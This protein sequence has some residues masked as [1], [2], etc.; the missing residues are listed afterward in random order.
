MKFIKQITLILISLVVFF[1]NIHPSQTLSNIPGIGNI[2]LD[3]KIDLNNL[4]K[5]LQSE[6]INLEKAEYTLSGT[7]KTD[8]KFHNIISI[9]NAVAAYSPIKEEVF[10]IG[11]PVIFGIM[12]PG[13]VILSSKKEGGKWSELT[14]GGQITS[15]SLGDLLPKE[16]ENVKKELELVIGPL[17]TIEK[18]KIEINPTTK[19]ISIIG[20][21]KFFM[22]ETKTT[23]N[24]FDAEDKKGIEI[25]AEGGNLI[26]KKY[27]DNLQEFI[28]L[29]TGKIPFQLPPGIPSPADVFKTV[30]EFSKG[31]ATVA[32]HLALPLP[33]DEN[34][35]LEGIK[36]HIK[37]L[38]IKEDFDTKLDVKAEVEAKVNRG[39]LLPF[40]DKFL[41]V[42]QQD[43]T[44]KLTGLINLNQLIVMF[45]AD[46]DSAFK[47]EAGPVSVDP[48][49]R[50]ELHLTPAPRLSIQG[51]I[52]LKFPQ[53]YDPNKFDELKF[54][55]EA[56]P[57]IDTIVF[58]GSMEGMWKNA[59]GIPGFDIGNL[60]IESDSWYAAMTEG[61]FIT[62][63]GIT[64]EVKIGESDIRVAVALAV[65]VDALILL[66]EVNKISLHDIL[67]FS[68]KIMRIA[69]PNIS[70]TMDSFPKIEFTDCKLFLAP[71]PGGIG[72]LNF[73]PG[74]TLRGKLN[75]M[76]KEGMINIVANIAG[77]TAE[78]SLPTLEIPSPI[79]N[80]TLFKMTGAGLDKIKGTKDD[81]PT[82]SIQNN[83]LKQEF[84]LSGFLDVLGMTRET[85]IHLSKEGFQFFIEGKLF[86]F[87]DAKLNAIGEIPQV[88]GDF[89][90]FSLY[91]DLE[92]FGKKG[93][94]NISLSK[95][96]AIGNGSL[97]TIDIPS[98]IHNLP[99]FRMSGAGLDQKKGTKDDGPS[100]SVEL[101]PKK[102]E[103]FLDGELDVLG[104]SSRTNV[105]VTPQGGI[106][107]ATSGK[108][109]GLFSTDLTVDT[110]PPSKPILPGDIP[111]F[112]KWFK[113]SQFKASLTNDFAQLLQDDFIKN[114]DAMIK[115]TR[116]Y[117]E[118]K[119]W[120]PW[121][122]TERGIAEV[123][124][125]TLNGIK[126]VIQNIPLT[127]KE[128]T[129]EGTLEDLLSSNG[130]KLT[131]LLSIK[132]NV[133]TGPLFPDIKIKRDIPLEAQFSLINP[134]TNIGILA[135]A[136][137]NAVKPPF[138]PKL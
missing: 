50:L 112:V 125:A 136:I 133:P 16:L 9:K 127:L 100:I 24:L 103:I 3:K 51:N 46:L 58:S 49:L 1:A 117:A 17:P 123:K 113:T 30:R 59:F 64:G 57:G 20:Q 88:I 110:P 101:T 107:F 42:K 12:F 74:L 137:W 90:K 28:A 80:I 122:L 69:I 47:I 72:A 4:P 61:I 102:Q 70:I 126:N 62:G 68:Q 65:D 19:Q 87:F 5:K 118:S 111:S 18:V 84:F 115:R 34:V 131:I 25:I 99:L 29:Q 39:K 37:A 23:I 15:L 134:I 120:W 60:A 66:A 63:L 7:I 40:F 104:V 79:P 73:E 91:G 93:I 95:D 10:V 8:I 6:N 21:A 92:L 45:S 98:L 119:G 89:P 48:G 38:S 36:Y 52:T 85:E 81:G 76:G 116:D 13:T 121:D 44:I 53:I 96:E 138:L 77:L 75:I 22:L 124:I 135:Q 86:N 56:A 114:I 27:L 130:A 71:M 108:L 26:L 82:I 129:L 32:Q 128:G 55:L 97:P 54:T 41:F 106:H 35:K 83:A 33:F 43:K 78:G 31:F 2:T 132:L 11:D 94:V 67:D 105:K 14:F 109:Q